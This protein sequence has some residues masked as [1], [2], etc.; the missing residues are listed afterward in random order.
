MLTLHCRFCRFGKER[1][2]QEVDEVDERESIVT[3]CTCCMENEKNVNVL[4]KF[5]LKHLHNEYY[6]MTRVLFTRIYRLHV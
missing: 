5:N 4:G 2:E 6:A 1:N 3:E